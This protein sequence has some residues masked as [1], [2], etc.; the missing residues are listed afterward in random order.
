MLHACVSAAGHDQPHTPTYLALRTT[1]LAAF[2][3]TA[4]IES[5]QK[6]VLHASVRLRARVYGNAGAVAGL[7]F[8]YD[9]ACESDIE[10]LTADPTTHVRYSNQPT[11]DAAGDVIAAASHD[12]A[13]PDGTAWTEWNE[14]R[15]D[16]LPGRSAWYV[17]GVGVANMTYGVPKLPSS[18]TLNLWS[19]GGVWSGEMAVGGEA[20]LQ[21]QWI[22][23]L[24][25][26]SGPVTGPPGATTPRTGS[27]DGAGRKRMR[28]SEGGCRVPCTVDGVRRVGWPEYAGGG[29]VSAVGVA[30]NEDR[31]RGT[32][33]L[34]LLGALA[35]AAVG[36]GE[37]AFAVLL[38][39]FAASFV[40]GV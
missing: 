9:D 10:I 30:V 5:L 17:N 7:F 28:R 39:A 22:E 19:D 31:A 37:L 16:W 14:H 2:Q 23:M 18:L 40:V 29:A 33:P 1:R 26:T 24:F 32:V 13:L 12:V 15:I 20:A 11:V 6:N 34:A 35:V 36:E 8:Y 4:E 38:L 25:N 3:S 27:V 21:I